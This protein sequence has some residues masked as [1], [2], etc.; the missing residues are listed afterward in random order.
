MFTD[1]VIVDGFRLEHTARRAFNKSQQ[2]SLA[3]FRSLNTD[4]FR[5]YFF[6]IFYIF[7]SKPSQII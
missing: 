7:K 6:C 4:I 5:Y 1:F 3:V 2:N